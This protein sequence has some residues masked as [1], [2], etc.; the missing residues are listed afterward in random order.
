MNIQRIRFAAAPSRTWILY[1]KVLKGLEADI[2]KHTSGGNP[3]YLLKWTGDVID[4]I[5]IGEIL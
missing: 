4:G 1:P 2:W 3:K 5:S